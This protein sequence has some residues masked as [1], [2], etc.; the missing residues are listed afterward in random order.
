[1]GLDGDAPQAA[2]RAALGFGPQRRVAG[3]PLGRRPR[4]PA[5]AWRRAVGRHGGQRRPVGSSWIST[6]PS[7]R[8]RYRQGAG[9]GVATRSAADCARRSID[10]YPARPPERSK[11]GERGGGRPIRGTWPRLVDR[12]KVTSSPAASRAAGRIIYTVQSS[13]RATDAGSPRD[14]RLAVVDPGSRSGRIALDSERVVRDGDNGVRHSR[15]VVWRSPGC[16]RG[17]AGG[18]RGSR[19]PRGGRHPGPVGRA[20]AAATGLSI[21]ASSAAARRA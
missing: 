1:M 11:E 12:G 20:L 21:D 10:Q 6:S 8:V 4:R 7:R 14:R 9:S 16:W 19:A 3:P 15:F 2:C 17:T 18:S 13:L 5:V